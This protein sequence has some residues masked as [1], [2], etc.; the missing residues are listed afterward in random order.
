MKYAIGIDFGTLSARA[1]IVDI[2]TGEELA[3]CESKYS[4]GVMESELPD[5]V[6]LEEGFSLQDPM[7]YL[8]SLDEVISEV[9]SKVADKKSICCIGI[10]FTA[11]TV[12]PVNKE[13]VPLCTYK[14]FSSDPQAWVKLWKHHA[15]KEYADRITEI[16][17]QNPD[18]EWILKM[19]GGKISP[20]SLLCKLLE[21]KEKSPNLYDNMHVY[22]EAGDWLVWQMTGNFIRSEAAAGIC[23]F[24]RKGTGYPSREFLNKLSPDF[25]EALDH[26]LSGEHIPIGSSAGKLRK[27][28]AT[29]WGLSENIIV[30]AALVDSQ[31]G[32]P[33]AGLFSQDM[34]LANI[35]TSTVFLLL[36][37]KEIF[38]KGMGACSKD[39][40][41]PGYYGYSA[42]QSCVGDS[43]A[44]FVS[45][46][47][48]CEYFERAEKDNLD[49][50]EYLTQ[51]IKDKR[52]GQSGVVALDWWTGNRCVL[53]DMNLSGLMTGLTLSTKPEDIYMALIEATA[54]GARK[55][56][57]AFKNG[58][59]SVKGLV[60]AGGIPQKNRVMMQIYSDVLNLPITICSSKNNVAL[61]S[62]VLASFA[63][64]C[65][66]SAEEAIKTLCKQ[67]EER[68]SPIAENVLAYNE[69][70]EMYCELHD[71]FG[72]NEMMKILRGYKH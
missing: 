15:A 47:I 18:D 52:P 58:G 48:P 55:I 54:Y 49:I 13:G 34:V 63:G 6:K 35:G 56:V 68:I 57:D 39:T 61:G 38:V 67:S 71:Y 4:H 19:Y 28:L 23:G 40:I 42:G 17:A 59:I 7:D 3:F 65:F 69:L 30:S 70:F 16:A 60:A 32:V 72:N 33:G 2:A 9:S 51:L 10:D 43:F 12:L 26:Q 29:K 50:Q 44:A 31:A 22:L 37:D 45:N 66:S 46:Y 11:C 64:G 5:G 41:L 21:A 62:A 25:G 53:A 14:E 27:E 36:G 1:I 20:E 24:W 8:N